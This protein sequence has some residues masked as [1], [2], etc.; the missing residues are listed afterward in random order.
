MPGID[1][2]LFDSISSCDVDTRKSLYSNIILAGGTTMHKGN[3]N[4]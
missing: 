3:L 4:A 2:V 1:K